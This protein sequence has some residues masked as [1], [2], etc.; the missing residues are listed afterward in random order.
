MH[1]IDYFSC[2]QHELNDPEL[3]YPDFLNKMYSTIT[4][5]LE[6]YITKKT[7]WIKY[8]WMKEKYNEVVKAILNSRDNNLIQNGEYELVEIYSSLKLIE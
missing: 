2:S 4:N 8:S 3:D 5:G 1:Y 7:V 6:K